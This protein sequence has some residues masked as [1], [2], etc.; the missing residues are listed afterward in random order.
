[1]LPIKVLRLI[2]HCCVHDDNKFSPI[3]LEFSMFDVNAQKDYTG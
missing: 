1:M 2:L 3:I